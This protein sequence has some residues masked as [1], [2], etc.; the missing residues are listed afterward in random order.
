MNERKANKA[1]ILESNIFVFEC[2]GRDSYLAAVRSWE[3]NKK[4]LG[5]WKFTNEEVMAATYGGFYARIK[6]L[7]AKV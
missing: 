7:D 2:E 4:G 3:R 6:T 5:E 1:T